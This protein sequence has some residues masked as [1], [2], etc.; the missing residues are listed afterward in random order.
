MAEHYKNLWDTLGP[1]VEEAIKTVVGHR[2]VNQQLLMLADE[3]SNYK[4][5]ASQKYYEM[6]SIIQ[7]QKRK[8]ME[9]QQV[10]G[11]SGY[12]GSLMSTLTTGDMKQYNRVADK[13]PNC[14]TPTIS[15]LSTPEQNTK[16]RSTHEMRLSG[17][18]CVPAA[19]RLQWLN[20]DLAKEVKES[21]A[22]KAKAEEDAKDEK[23]KEDCG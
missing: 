10:N 17:M 18:S 22:A 4:Q 15:D 7:R 9:L 8:E 19:K 1:R 13:Y 6:S 16:Q 5:K 12:M 20:E 23:A 21:A 2:Q 3:Y 14:K 11:L